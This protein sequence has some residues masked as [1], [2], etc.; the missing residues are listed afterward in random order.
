MRGGGPVRCQPRESGEATVR[1]WTGRW[2]AG[3]QEG[4]GERVWAPE[5][6]IQSLCSDCPPEPCR[7]E[8]W[9]LMINLWPWEVGFGTIRG[10]SSPPA[11]LLR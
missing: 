11:G 3:Q 5:R 10:L 4:S 1:S 8:H 7:P 9:F 6:S 2:G